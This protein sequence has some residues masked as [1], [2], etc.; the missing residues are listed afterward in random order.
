MGE[1]LGI[2]YKQFTISGEQA[3]QVL[4]HS[5]SVSPSNEG[6]V[7]LY[8]ANGTEWTEF[9][10]EVPADETLVVN[11]CAFGQYFKLSGNESDV[12]VIY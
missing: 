1:K 11:G 6:Y 3:F 7:L 10:E 8:S 4:S 2:M 12:Q 9:E 5:F